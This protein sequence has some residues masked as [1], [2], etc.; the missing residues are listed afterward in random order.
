MKM[1]W[2]KEYEK[3]P[4][5]L[6]DYLLATYRLKNDSMLA[7]T[8][9]VKKPTISKVRNRAMKVGPNFILAVHDAFGLSI[10][11]IKALAQASDEER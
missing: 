8:L 3:R 1:V 9:E 7:D 11:E 2:D 10:K 4:H 6:L 5:K